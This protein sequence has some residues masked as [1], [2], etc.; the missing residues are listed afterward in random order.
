MPPKKLKLL[1][2]KVSS[3]RLIICRGCPFD[4]I[5]ARARGEHVVRLDEH[6]TEC[7]CTLIAK[8]KCL[9][10]SCP[11]SKWTALLS[12]EESSKIQEVVG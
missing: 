9:H 10:C 12:E 8:T 4:S 2:D 11:L 6:C 3:E 5:N 7:G 1:I